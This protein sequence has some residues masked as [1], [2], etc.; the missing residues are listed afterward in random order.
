[1][2]KLQQVYKFVNDSGVFK[3]IHFT[4]KFGK[5]PNT[6]WTYLTYLKRAQYVI[7]F[8]NDSTM[9]VANGGPAHDMSHDQLK[10]EAYGSKP[11]RTFDR[12]AFSG[13]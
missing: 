1:M 5:Y 12:Q 4:K 13:R 8:G 7:S 6:Y 9:T 11:Y 2:T 10:R 3:N